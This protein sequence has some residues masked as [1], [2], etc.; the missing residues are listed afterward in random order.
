MSGMWADFQRLYRSCRQLSWT[1][2][3]EFGKEIMNSESKWIAGF[4]RRIGAFFIDVAIIATIGMVLGYVFENEFVQI[5]NLGRLF[6]IF[7]TTIYFGFLNSKVFGG[8]TIGKKILKIRVVD[9]TNNILSL[10]RSLIRYAIFFMPLFLNGV[11]L[12]E[13][14]SSKLFYSLAIMITFGVNLSATYLYIFNWRTRQSLHDIAVG[15]Y[16]V[17]VSNEDNKFASLQKTHKMHYAVVIVIFFM[18]AALSVYIKNLFG[19][20]N[21]VQLNYIGDILIKE[22]SLVDISVSSTDFYINKNSEDKNKNLIITA[23]IRSN[24]VGDVEFAKKLANDAMIIYTDAKKINAV[25][26]NMVYGFDIGI[27]S[28]WS[29]YR[30]IF[31]QEELGKAKNP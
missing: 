30:H 22:K 24:N 25:Q 29:Y 28:K 16:V 8:Q 23:Y 10:P 1:L 31:T 6:G 3:I 13:S 4:W 27:A 15:S 18:A 21:L 20:I 26:V 17:N 11:Q 14:V 9:S 19:D 2:I 5:G 7:V 12:P